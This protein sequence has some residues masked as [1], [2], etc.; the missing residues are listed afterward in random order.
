MRLNNMIPVL[1]VMA[2]LLL[3]QSAAA[4]ETVVLIPKLASVEVTCQFKDGANH[5]VQ[6]RT[7]QNYPMFGVG[8]TFQQ[9]VDYMFRNSVSNQTLTF[10][11][12]VGDRLPSFPLPRGIYDLTIAFA[13]QNGPLRGTAQILYKGI[14]VPQILSTSGRGSGCAFP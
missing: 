11:K 14:S 5:T 10:T 6:I 8:L 9:R 2:G 7:E 13:D 1:A 12:T 3:P 4:V